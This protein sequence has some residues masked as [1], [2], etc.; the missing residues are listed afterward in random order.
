VS[1]GRKLPRPAKRAA[2]RAVAAVSECPDCGVKAV[3]PRRE[4]DGLRT[5]WIVDIPHEATCPARRLPG[6]RDSMGVS[7]V[8]RARPGSPV[9]LEYLPV[10]GGV[11]IAGERAAE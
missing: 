9:P 2:A 6:L 5:V 3:R 7:A 10:A 1:N 11:V 8:Q 4:R